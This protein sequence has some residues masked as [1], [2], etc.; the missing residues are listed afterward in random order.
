MRNH[1]GTHLLHAALRQVLG[2][3]VHQSGSAVDPERM[4][5][6]FNFPPR[7]QGQRITPD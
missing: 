1:T 5:F 4:R 3:K 2:D 6:D 7:P